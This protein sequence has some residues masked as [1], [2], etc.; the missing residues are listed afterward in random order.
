MM[1]ALGDFYLLFNIFFMRKEQIVNDGYYHVYNR[2]VDRR[3]T[4]G[5]DNDRERFIRSM[6]AFNDTGD[7]R[8]VL[9]R[10][11]HRPSPSKNPLVKIMS[12][13]I[14]P[15]HYHFLLKQ[16]SDN[17]VSRFMQKLGVG[18][19][20]YFNRQNE[21][22]GRL[23]ESEYKAVPIKSDAQ[24]LHISRYIHFNPLKLFLP[25]WK[26]RGIENWDV[27]NALLTSYPW[28]SYSHYLMLV[29][30]PI[31]SMD[32]LSNLFQGK[33]DYQKFMREWSGVRN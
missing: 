32:I 24:L 20:Q 30:D 33:S 13:A 22:T 19:A 18:F 25:D 5:N 21:R 17:G 4:Y 2:G 16:V 7:R 23:W 11:Q 28:S 31:V 1:S 14:M 29:H 3:S 6:L 27:A 10:L 15:N 26:I 12:Y 9:H 8:I